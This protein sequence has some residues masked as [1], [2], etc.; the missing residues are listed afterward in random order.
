MYL[1]IC[2]Y[3]NSIKRPRKKNG[4]GPKKLFFRYLKNGITNFEKLVKQ[5]AYKKTFHLISQKGGWY[6]KLEA[7]KVYMPFIIFFL[8]CVTHFRGDSYFLNSLF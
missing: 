8:M 6:F 3:Y 5:N 7:P 1:A 4:S 2:N